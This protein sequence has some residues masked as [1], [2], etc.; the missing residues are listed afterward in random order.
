MKIATI[1]SKR[2][3]DLIIIAI[4]LIGL[5]ILVFA[6]YQVYQLVTRASVEAVPKNVALSNLTTSSVTVSWVTEISATGSVI[7]VE[8][9]TEQSPVL[10]KRGS[11][12]RDTHYVE[13]VNLEPN[14][15]YQFIIVSGSKEYTNTQ[16]V[17]FAFKTPPI[18]ADM[19]TPNPIHGSVVGVSGDDVMLFA[20]LKD[21]STYPVSAIMPRGGNWIMDMSALR[22]ISDKALVKVSDS[23]NI[24]LIAITGM[25]RGALVEGTYAELFDSNGKLKDIHSL[26]ISTNEYLYAFFPPD[27]VLDVYYEE[28]IVVV[29]PIDTTPLPFVYESEIDE[30]FERRYRLVNDLRWIDMVTSGG[31]VSGASGAVTVQILNLTDTGFY[32]VW[33]SERREE[34]YVAYGTSGE[35]LSLEANDQRDGIT[36]RNPYYV[37]IVSLSR[38]LPET[39]YF[40]E[41]NSGNEIYD[42]AGSK[43]R[44]TTFPTLASPPPF[45]SAQGEV[46]GI[47]EHGEAVL[48]A[49]INDE[50][51]LGSAGESSKIV[52]SIDE[53]GRWILSIGDARTEDGLS[54][55]EYTSGDTLYIDVLTT[56]STSISQERMEGITDRDIEIVLEGSEDVG[57]TKVDLLDN[58]G[59]LGYSTGVSIN[60]EEGE[61]TEGG[62]TIQEGT[63]TPK[64]GLFDVVGLVSLS[65][66]VLVVT[67]VVVYISKVTK[68]GKRGNMKDNI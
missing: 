6:S 35:S 1:P 31:I 47:P 23:T 30:D 57:Y 65:I 55:F 42:N 39:E 54:Y 56:F 63:E 62:Y 17:N 10:D 37:H 20:M 64:T 26:N 43:Y 11:A 44:V 52:G 50:D 51:G 33:V 49:Q 2:R 12:R 32:V 36:S 16:D 68:K 22:N 28:T 60:F 59:I 4:L 53:N 27:S 21:K 25:D 67:T 9:N 29:E 3:K 24:V 34:G 8:N 18:T 5:P 61:D 41:V 38:L 40:F 45:D 13:L 7:P 15:E 48:I 19:P 58:Y 66:L 46:E 14:T